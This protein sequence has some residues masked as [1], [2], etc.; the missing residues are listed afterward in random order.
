MEAAQKRAQRVIPIGSTPQPMMPLPTQ[1]HRPMVQPGQ[2]PFLEPTN[3]PQ[4][5]VTAGMPFGPGPGPEVL[6]SSVAPSRPVTQML[7]SIA[8]ATNGG[9]AV[10]ALADS[11]RALGL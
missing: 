8:N 3:R 1:A 4:E 11:A 6:G 9:H 2:L 7:D 10:S 5:P